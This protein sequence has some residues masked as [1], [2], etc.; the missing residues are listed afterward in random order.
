MTFK[1]IFRGYNFWGNKIIN[2]K[3]DNPTHPKHLVNKEFVEKSLVYET[4]KSLQ[5]QN[6]FKQWWITNINQKT[7][8]QIFD[9]LFFPRILPEYLNPTAK[10]E[11]I[12]NINS[13]TNQKIIYNGKN[14]VGV[15]FFE[16]TGNDRVKDNNLAKIVI[17]YPSTANSIEFFSEELT[18]TGRIDF[19]FTIAKDMKIF[20]VQN[21]LASV[22]KQDSYGENYI[23]SEFSNSYELRV[24]L[25]EQFK[26]KFS[27][28]DLY[29][30][31]PNLPE[32]TTPN[33]TEAQIL[34]TFTNSNFLNFGPNNYGIYHILVPID[35]FKTLIFQFFDFNTV[36]FIAAEVFLPN[37]LLNHGGLTTID[38]NQE[39][40][41]IIEVNFGYAGINKKEVLIDCF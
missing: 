32:E 16:L 33:Y 10:C 12:L 35:N 4:E 23:T 1:N 22:V 13:K 24:E 2:A 26:S 34:S 39:S 6:P 38:V 20:F 21:Y 37:N 40:F 17:E 3:T 5:Y 19:N 28:S 8:L 30:I 9:D 29:W 25:T 14:Y 11:F 36:Q 31:S 18:D 41:Y 7:L 27:I 15:L